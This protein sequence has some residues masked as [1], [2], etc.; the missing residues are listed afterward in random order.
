MEVSENCDL[1]I[2]EALALQIEGL[3][4]RNP[5]LTQGEALTACMTAIGSIVKS[6]RCRDCRK[7]TAQLVKKRLPLFIREALVQAIKR[8][9][10]EPATNQHGH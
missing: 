4:W 6:I 2:A 10:N 7:L 3:I 9:A 8:D 5:E 1:E